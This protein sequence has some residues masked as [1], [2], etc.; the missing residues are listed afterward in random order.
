MAYTRRL[1]AMRVLHAEAQDLYQAPDTGTVV[2]RDVVLVNSSGAVLTAWQLYVRPL[3]KTGQFW[4][5]TGLNVP[6]GTTHIDL[7]QVLELRETLV[8]YSSAADY[9]VA[10]TGYVFE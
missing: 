6:V 10:I 7:R 1:A 4:L 8:A 5:Y 3:T 2:I 9:S